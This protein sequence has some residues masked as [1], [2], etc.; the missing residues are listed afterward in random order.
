M[1]SVSPELLEEA[2]RF[3]QNYHALIK[4]YPEHKEKFLTSLVKL[5]VLASWIDFDLSKIDIFFLKEFFL[6]YL[7]ISENRYS[8]LLKRSREEIQREDFS[9]DADQLPEQMRIF[10]YRFWLIIIQADDKLYSNFSYLVDQSM[11]QVKNQLFP[12]RDK[13]D[14][15]EIHPFAVPAQKEIEKQ[16][17]GSGEI[18][19]DKEQQTNDAKISN[20]SQK[21]ADL[22]EIWQDLDRL[23]G[24]EDL[25]YEIKTLINFLSIQQKRKEQ[26]LPG[27]KISYHT[28][29]T[30]NPGTGKT[31]V[32]RI[33]GKAF[34][35]MNFLPSGHVVETDRSGLV[36][37]YIGHTAIKTDAL[38]KKALGG[39]L[40]IDEAYSLNKSSDQG[41]DFGEEAIDTLLKR[42]E[43]YRDEFVV[44]V[45]GYNQE[46]QDFIN[47]NP[48]LQSRFNNFFHFPDFN[49][50]E[51]YRIFLKFC[52]SE[53]YLLSDTASEKI[54]DL[55]QDVY[56]QKGPHFGNARTIRNIFQKIIRLQANRLIDGIEFDRHSLQTIE[57]EDIPPLEKINYN[58]MDVPGN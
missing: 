50:K 54:R 56:S 49:A 20:P 42:M 51:L 9:I 17:S 33:L 5:T 35:A 22:K 18:S 24:L 15:N 30:G 45:A 6:Q 11:I 10:A 36:G 48:G 52:E 2:N 14:R 1:S 3:A 46:M 23:I 16:N 21:K 57:T 19:S 41:N 31:T 27:S 34:S 43:D 8:P 4:K 40:F 44:I 28:V 13:E 26:G 38:I 39:V 7:A 12:D 32:A 53:H 47:S 29:F 55:I 37:Q 58:V 25:K